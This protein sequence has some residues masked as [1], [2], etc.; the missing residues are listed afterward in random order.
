MVLSMTVLFSCSD[1]PKTPV[2]EKVSLKGGFKDFKACRAVNEKKSCRTIMAKTICGH[3]GI[4]DFARLAKDGWSYTSD[5]KFFEELKSSGKWI[6]AGKADNKDVLAK[7]IAAI[8]EG[9]ASLA[10]RDGKSYQQVAI[11]MEGVTKSGKYG[12]V[13]LAT[14]FRSD[15]PEKSFVGK[16]LN[17]AFG[18]LSEVNIWIRK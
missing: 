14:V 16:G 17:Y 1:T 4:Q 9:K 5:L 11:L 15:K 10:I 12:E 7:S 13:P 6:D 2:M 8:K 3:F 18:D